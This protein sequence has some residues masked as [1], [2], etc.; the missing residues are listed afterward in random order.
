MYVDILHVYVQIYMH[1][2]YLIYLVIL[3]PFINS[4]FVK[5]CNVITP[6]PASE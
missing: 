3:L 1:L 4:S 6:T 2:S 5:C